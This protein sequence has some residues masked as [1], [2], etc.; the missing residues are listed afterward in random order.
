MDNQ[1]HQIILNE[2]DKKGN[3]TVASLV[4]L[5]GASESSIRRDLVELDHQG[6]LKRVHG[7]ATLI[8]KV[9]HTIEDPLGKRQLLN[10]DEKKKIAKYA[11]GMI[12]ANDVVYLDAGS[13]TLELIEYLDQKEA[14]YITNG[15]MQAQQL[16]LKGFHV[17]CLGG[18]V[19]NITGACVGAST[20]KLLSRYHFSKGFFG[21]NGIDLMNGFT[22]P[23]SEEAVIKELAMERCQMSY[24]LSDHSKFNKVYHVTFG[25]I[26]DAVIIT[27]HCEKEIKEQ[28]MNSKNEFETIS[29]GKYQ[30]EGFKEVEYNVKTVLH[31]FNEDGTTYAVVED[32]DRTGVKKQNEKIENPSLLDWEVIIKRNVGKKEQPIRNT[33]AESVQEDISA[34]QDKIIRETG[35]EIVQKSDF[36]Q[37][38]QSLKDSIFDMIQ[39]ISSNQKRKE[40]KDECE[41]YNIP[42]GTFQK[43]TDKSQ[44][45]QMKEITAAFL[46]RNNIH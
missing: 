8:P 36:D 24:V 32:K 12:E 46:T 20:M 13:S 1:R 42:A 38:L 22:T 16:T 19:R 28:K 10:A 45:Q 26:N 21:T 44:L 5:T 31:T 14:H 25:Q 9:T 17:V 7:G 39:K 41:K 43:I 34:I 33:V 35:E 23:D 40:L 37:E 3:V 6:F 18:E 30:P 29:T 4:E 27:D 2:L 15:L 11:A